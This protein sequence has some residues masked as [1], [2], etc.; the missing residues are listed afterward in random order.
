[1]DFKK[2]QINI[3]E[4]EA[5]HLINEMKYLIKK[6]NYKYKEKY[7]CLLRIFDDY[8]NNIISL[9]ELYKIFGNPYQARL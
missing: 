3:S 6:Q 1:M 9:H 8:D 2:K 5:R 7:K 4:N